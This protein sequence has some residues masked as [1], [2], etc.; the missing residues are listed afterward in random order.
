MF[1][2]IGCIVADAYMSPVPLGAGGQ[3]LPAFD[4]QHASIAHLT[5]PTL[6]QLETIYKVFL[7]LFAVSEP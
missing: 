1:I 5:G 2:K 4:Q 7:V 6:L 3:F